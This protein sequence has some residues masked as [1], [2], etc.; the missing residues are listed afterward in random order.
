MVNWFAVFQGRYLAR[1]EVLNL[2][3]HGFI[4][5]YGHVRRTNMESLFCRGETEGHAPR[6]RSLALPFS[7][8]TLSRN[9]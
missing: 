9:S 5:C 1:E 7:G 2:A 6:Q 3:T 8:L 4:G